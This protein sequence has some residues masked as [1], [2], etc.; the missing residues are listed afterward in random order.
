MKQLDAQ[1]I[2]LE[3]EVDNAAALAFYSRLNFIRYKRMHAFY[4]NRKDAFRLLLP[5]ERPEPPEA[6]SAPADI[7]GT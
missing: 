6:P 4:L 5:L 2:V 3:T 1:E 7:D